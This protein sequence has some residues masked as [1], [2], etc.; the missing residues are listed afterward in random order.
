MNILFG[1]LWVGKNSF[2]LRHGSANST[3]KVERIRDDTQRG[4]FQRLS[5]KRIREISHACWERDDHEKAVGFFPQK[6]WTYL[7]E[8]KNLV[9][10]EGEKRIDSVVF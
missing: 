4:S 1:R 7:A 2:G 3:E 8:H 9:K 6:R 5:K 10:Q